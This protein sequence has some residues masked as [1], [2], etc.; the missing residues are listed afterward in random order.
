MIWKKSIIKG[1]QIAEEF[2]ETTNRECFT[3]AQKAVGAWATFAY[4][5]GNKEE[6]ISLLELIADEFLADGESTT[7]SKTMVEYFDSNTIS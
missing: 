7:L 6:A 3:F 4:V 1:Q 2:F 5:T